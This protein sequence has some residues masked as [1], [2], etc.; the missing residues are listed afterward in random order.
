MSSQHVTPV[1][2][3]FAACCG[4]LLT[5]LFTTPFDLVKTRL[6][7]QSLFKGSTV[8]NSKSYSPLMSC[9][10]KVMYSTQNM[11]REFF[12]RSDPR[13]PNQSTISCAVADTMIPS[14]IAARHQLN[15]LNGFLDGFI[16]I[17]R[18]EGIT[19][20]WRGLSPGV[21]MSVPLTVIYFVGYD[22]IRDSLWKNWKG[23]YSETYSPLLAG[24]LA[25][26][27][28]VS[29]ISPIELFR[30]RM[31]G[32]EGVNGLKGV[33]NGVQNMVRKNGISS[34]WRGLEP[35]LWRDVPFSGYEVIKR[36][37]SNHLR[38]KSIDGNI[39]NFSVAFVSATLTTPFDVAK[40][41]RQ[42]TSNSMKNQNMIKVM[43]RIVRE[44]GYQGLFRGLT[45]P[46]ATK[47]G[48]TIIGL[49]F[50]DGVILA[51]DT[52]STNGPIVA[53]KNCEKLHYLAP[54]MYC[55][56]AGTAA[57]TEQS[58]ALISSQLE[59]HRLATGRS[60]RVVTAVTMLKQMLFRYQGHIGAALI[61]GGYDVSGPGLF[62]IHPHGSTEKLPY[63]TMG[64]G[65][66]AAM[67]ILESRWTKDL[68]R[69]EAIELA[70]DAIEAAQKEQSYKY[71]RGTTAYLKESIREFIV[72]EGDAMDIS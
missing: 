44:E 27:I 63:V 4:A 21:V 54:N 40:T 50:K 1:E 25:R 31:Q 35:T 9:C 64:S 33:M 26:T 70:K 30:T 2:K 7:S 13:I 72:T 60:A 28:S 45:L 38:N 14:K 18:Y 37:F 58:T 48:T 68:E 19:S 34:L 59:L 36:K 3:M 29:I 6:Q 51:A 61:V 15:E 47:T 66:L 57:D 11:H 67:S 49:I 12:C 24:T 16:K 69:D 55:A 39:N 65:S 41:Q 62:N 42:V 56:G 17:V 32:P 5:S 22:S 20:L 46:K 53:N 71:K 52:R 23:K 43:Q 10:Q 8:P